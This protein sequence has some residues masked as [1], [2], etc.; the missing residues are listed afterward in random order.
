MR[1]WLHE[2]LFLFAVWAFMKGGEYLMDERT[3]KIFAA[4][5]VTLIMTGRRTLNDVPMNLI[6]YVKADL[7]I[8]D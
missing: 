1:R 5:Y 2:R 4:T 3:L 7:G 8:T 6:D